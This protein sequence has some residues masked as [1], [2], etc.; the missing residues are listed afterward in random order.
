MRGCG[1]GCGTK[2][3][4]NMYAVGSKPKQDD[5]FQV[6][7]FNGYL[8]V[9]LALVFISIVFNTHQNKK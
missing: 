4:K 9:V 5:D 3:N 7:G 1:C 8:V 2:Q 6:A